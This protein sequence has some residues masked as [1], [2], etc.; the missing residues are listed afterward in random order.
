M[1]FVGKPAYGIELAI[2]DETTGKELEGPCNGV[3]AI[4]SISPSFAR[5]IHK[6]HQVRNLV[7]GGETAFQ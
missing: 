3:L 7:F 6:D 2:L 1:H 4:K 5:T